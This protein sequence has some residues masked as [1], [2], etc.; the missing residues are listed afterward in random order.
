MKLRQTGNSTDPVF[1]PGRGEVVARGVT[2]RTL[3]VAGD[4]TPEQVV[5]SPLALPRV[6]SKVREP[7]ACSVRA[8]E[9]SSP[10]GRCN[11]ASVKRLKRR[12]KENSQGPVWQ[13]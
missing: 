2:G 13:R 7:G 4:L 5:P 12:H 8:G 10:H 6:T 11:P 9:R 3:G 1:L